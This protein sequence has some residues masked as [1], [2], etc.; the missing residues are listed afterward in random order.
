[1]RSA[2]IEQLPIEIAI[3]KWCLKKKKDNGSN[4]LVD[5]EDTASP[6]KREDE[7]VEAKKTNGDLKKRKTQP[8]GKLDTK[9]LEFTQ[10]YWVQVLSKVKP[11]NTSTEALLRAARPISY[12][13]ETLTLGV[14]YSFHKEK[15]ETNHHRML[16][17]SVIQEVVG[18]PVRVVCELTKQPK[19][20]KQKKKKNVVLTQSEDEDII[21]IA[22]EIFE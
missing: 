2:Y 18:N 1:M 15:L 5:E 22:E 10:E 11:E 3:V 12:D 6:D 21:K 9:K 19:Q 14:Y 8:E 17:E 20:T 13:G 16:L 4:A 7:K